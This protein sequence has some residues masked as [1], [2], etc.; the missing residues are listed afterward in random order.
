MKVNRTKLLETLHRVRP[1]LAA[2]EIIEQSTSFIFKDGQV[3][4]Y[5][6][7]I[8]VHAPLTEKFEIEGAVPAKELISI[9]SRWKGDE[10]EIEA[11][12]NELLL[13]CGKGK[14]GIKLSNEISLPVDEIKIPKKWNPLPGDFQQAIK[15]CILSAARDMTY[16]ILTTLHITEQCVE[17]TDNNRITRWAWDKTYKIS[18][19][20][21]PVESAASLCRFGAIKFQHED[22]RAQFIDERGVVFSCRTA[23]GDYPDLSEAIDIDAIGE[24]HFPT[25]IQEILDRAGVFV[26]GMVDSDRNV[27]IL[28]DEKGLMKIEGK[29]DYGWYEESVRVKWNGSKT[30][31][32]IHPDHLLQILQTVKSAEI[33]NDR[34]LFSAERFQHIVALEVV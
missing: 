7:E 33:G 19:F 28:I 1:G 5:N 26:S 24:L 23:E 14:A 27:S 16:P 34:I 3:I 13:K 29:S 9:L 10:V 20:L 6:D 8:A 11:T 30:G 15:S 12:E 18:P 32:S 22:G 25:N 21:L 4:T 17:S 31:F 2:K